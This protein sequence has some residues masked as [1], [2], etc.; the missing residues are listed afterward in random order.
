[1]TSRN[2]AFGCAM[3]TKRCSRY[4]VFAKRFARTERIGT[5]HGWNLPTPDFSRTLC[6]DGFMLAGDARA[7][8]IRSR[9]RELETR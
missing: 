1:V 6:G 8:S 9:A 3:C 4:R 5:V 2:G 7:W